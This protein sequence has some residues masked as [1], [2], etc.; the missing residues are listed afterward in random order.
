MLDEEIG[1]S[2]QEPQPAAPDPTLGEARIKLE[3]AVYEDDRLIDIALEVADYE[4]G[5][6]EHI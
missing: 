5:L 4:S 6:A 3:R 2:G 1:L